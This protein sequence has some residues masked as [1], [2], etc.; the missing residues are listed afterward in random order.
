M[1]FL[2]CFFVVHVFR[3]FVFIV[4]VVN[5]CIVV[6]CFFTLFFSV[7]YSVYDYYKDKL[8]SRFVCLC[9]QREAVA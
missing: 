1:V 2:L 4:F 7:Y 6:L 9:V 8:F 3:L 5:A